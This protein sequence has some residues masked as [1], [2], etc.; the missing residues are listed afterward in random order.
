M[1]ENKVRG[2]TRQLKT[3]RP[4]VD[5]CVPSHTLSAEMLL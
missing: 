1:S 2:S 4:S 5:V 3:M